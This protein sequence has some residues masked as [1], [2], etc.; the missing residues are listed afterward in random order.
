[1]KIHP[2]EAEMFHA[3]ER[4]YRYDEANSRFL[5]F[6]NAPKKT[7]DLIFTGVRP[8]SPFQIYSLFWY[9]QTRSSSLLILRN[10][11]TRNYIK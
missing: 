1:M 7:A 11:S 4:T 3:D 10:I 9:K 8:S 5:K 6:A 2:V